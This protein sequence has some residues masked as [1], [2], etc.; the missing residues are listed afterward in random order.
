MEVKLPRHTVMRLSLYRRLLLKYRYLDEPYIFSHDL[1][2]MLGIKAVKVRHDLM[3]LGMA[4]DRR[5]GYHVNSLLRYISDTLGRH[6]EAVVL[7][8]MGML[9]HSLLRHM[10]ESESPLRLVAA[11][12]I[13]PGK[14]GKTFD[15]IPCH[16][17]AALSDIVAQEQAGIA[18]LAI[19]PDDVAGV[20]PLILDSGIR[21]ILNYTSLH[22]D[23]PEGVIV[24]NAN[25]MASLDEIAYYLHA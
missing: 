12:D 13:D 24:R 3:Q 21:G 17:I 18:I 23:V 25:P 16:G 6:A 9:G 8:G 10:Q 22:L 7:V 20:L 15:G 14:V 11:F 5:K 4:G 2:R 19:P 1:A